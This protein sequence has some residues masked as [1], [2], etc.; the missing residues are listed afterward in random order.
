MSFFDRLFG[1]RD[2]NEAVRPLYNAVIARGRETHWY[3]DG[4]V[5]DTIDGRFDMLAALMAILLIRLEAEPDE[6]TRLQSVLLTELFVED[7]D[8]SLHQI[9]VG[10]YVVGKHIGKMMSALGG[11]LGAF[12]QAAQDRDFSAPVRRNIFH[13]AAPSDA[14]VDAVAARLERFDAALL[15]MPAAEFAR[16][17]LPPL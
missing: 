7:M 16:G 12:R 4:G 9:G 17:K 10:D 1:R 8:E 3:V 13:D 6:E 2:A 14:V 5:P 11:R 15:A